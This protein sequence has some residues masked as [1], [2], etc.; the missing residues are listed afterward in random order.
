MTEKRDDHGSISFHFVRLSSSQR[1]LHTFG[2]GKYQ[3]CL[4]AN[5]H[6][7]REINLDISAGQRP[8]ARPLFLSDDDLCGNADDACKHRVS[9]ATV[10]ADFKH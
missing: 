9:L 3:I 7:L 5:S 10:H 1:K 2:T 8:H 4:S 6:C